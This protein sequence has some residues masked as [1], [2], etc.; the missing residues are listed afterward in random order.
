MLQSLPAGATLCGTQSQGDAAIE[1]NDIVIVN[2]ALT[3]QALVAFYT[4]LAEKLS[5]TQQSAGGAQGY[6]FN[7][8]NGQTFT[9][10]ANTAAAYLMLTYTD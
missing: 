4:P 6:L 3:G 2:S 5:C 7:C 8:P 1:D 9:V 10:V